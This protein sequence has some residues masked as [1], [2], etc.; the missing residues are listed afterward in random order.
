MTIEL[1]SQGFVFWNVGTGDSTTVVIDDGIVMQV[2]L[3]HL[4]AAD[5]DDD[6]RCAIVD[7]LVECL[8]VK[9]GRPYLSVFVLTHPD[10]DHCQGFSALMEKV[11]IGE[12][13]FTP[14]VFREYLK[15]LCED[16]QAFKRE[17]KR[18]LKIVSEQTSDIAAGDRLRVIGYDNILQ[19]DD[20]KNLPRERLSIPG[21][22]VTIID[23]VDYSGKF[24]AFIHSPF[25]EHAEGERNHTSLGMQVTLQSG[26]S[27]GRA[28]LLGDLC[29]PTVKHIFE[30][31]SAENLEWNIF[32]APHHCSKSVMYW[33]DSIDSVETHREDVM[34]LI[35]KNASGTAYVIASSNPIPPTN[36]P[37]DNPP[38]ALARARYE[39]IAVSGFLCTQEHP[40]EIDASPIVFKMRS[41]GLTYQSPAD[42]VP[43]I[44]SISIHDAVAGSRGTNTPPSHRVGYGRSFTQESHE[45]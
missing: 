45:S 36:S 18:R 15:D 13:W 27:F 37:G 21:S 40:N 3:R 11:T 12:L 38:H 30:I 39:E 35:E 24:R 6:P 16:A 1:P 28:M 14:R 7:R 9:D 44:S 17:A 31:S 23:E 32:L 34:K 29:Y 41:D 33:R 4:V 20:Y 25:L 10:L 19:K 26:E 42:C 8:P 2:D 43:V 22:S 5:D